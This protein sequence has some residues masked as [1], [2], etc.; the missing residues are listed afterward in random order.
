MAPLKKI[1]VLTLATL[2]CISPSL[3]Q[4]TSNSQSA[5]PTS[6]QS[7]NQSP[8]NAVTSPSSSPTNQG[9]V[10]SA[11]PSATSGSGSAT[12]SGSSSSPSPTSIDG[13]P[14]RLTLTEPQ[15]VYQQPSMLAIGY[16]I[17]FKWQYDKYLTI[18]PQALNI[19]VVRP[20]LNLEFP[21]AVNLTGTTTEFLWDTNT[22]NQTVAPLIESSDYQLRIFD[23]RGPKATWE[24]GRLAMYQ[25]AFKMYKPSSGP[26]CTVCVSSATRQEGSLFSAGMISTM[27]LISLQLFI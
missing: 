19:N 25:V 2:V 16:R 15:Q 9:S 13:Q 7:V 17:Q 5:T 4:E 3:T 23:E 22:W 21:I 11:N 8:S 12:G 26:I 24:A 1:V 6:N 18:L 27:A 20:S 14:G 10:I